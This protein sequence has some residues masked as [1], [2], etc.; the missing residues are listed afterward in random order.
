MVIT[1]PRLTPEI[2]ERFKAYH[3]A[4]LVWGRL[5]IVLD[6]L[7]FHDSCVEHAITWA[8]EENDAEGKALAELLLQMSKTQRRKLSRIA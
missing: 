3:Q 5:H 7:N 1:R 6:D 2:V 8:T 4:N